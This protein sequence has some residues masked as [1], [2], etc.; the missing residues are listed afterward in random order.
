MRKFVYLRST[1]RRGPAA[2]NIKSVKIMI[3]ELL[4]SYGA[5]GIGSRITDGA[6][7]ESKL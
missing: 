4:G 7:F 1:R 5:K 2:K 3:G 6:G